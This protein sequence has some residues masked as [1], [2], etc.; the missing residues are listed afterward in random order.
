MIGWAMKFQDR[1]R[2]AGWWTRNCDVLSITVWW[3]RSVDVECSWYR[4]ESCNLRGEVGVTC[5]QSGEASSIGLPSSI[6][7]RGVD[8]VAF[9]EV[10]DHVVDEADVINSTAVRI[11]FPFILIEVSWV[12]LILGDHKQLSSY[13]ETLWMN[14]DSIWIATPIWELAQ[15][16][17]LGWVL[18][19]S[20]EGEN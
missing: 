2:V 6:D 18:V 19:F 20:M 9:W 10:R 15:R 1:D 4:R 14:Y 5:K 7:P 3:R 12:L 8:A 16:F 13:M 17:L 11:S